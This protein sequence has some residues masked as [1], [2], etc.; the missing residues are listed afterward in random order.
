MDILEQSP[1]VH[2][3]YELIQHGL[4]L[5]KQRA[6]CGERRGEINNKVEFDFKQVGTKF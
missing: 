1:R 6:L 3:C 5:A 4:Q 2:E